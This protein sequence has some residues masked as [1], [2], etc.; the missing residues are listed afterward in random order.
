MSMGLTIGY[1][2]QV[3]NSCPQHYT[4]F[5]ISFITLIMPVEETEHIWLFKT[6]TI[7]IAHI[8]GWQFLNGVQREM[9]WGKENRNLGE[10]SL[11]SRETLPSAHKKLFIWMCYYSWATF[12]NFQQCKISYIFFFFWGMCLWPL[13]QSSPLSATGVLTPV[14]Y[15]PI[16]ERLPLLESNTVAVWSLKHPTDPLHKEFW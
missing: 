3:S 4:C 9:E 10:A 5:R 12:Q 7:P 6:K 1:R 16:L 13:L 14:A 11:D 8:S 2:S 15:G